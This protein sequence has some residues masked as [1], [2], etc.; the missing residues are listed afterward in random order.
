MLTSV[1][2]NRVACKGRRLHILDDLGRGISCSAGG[3]LKD[4][5]RDGCRKYGHRVERGDGGVK[6]Y[7]MNIG[8]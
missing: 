7:V 6:W 8:S 2:G 1:R 4:Y 3:A 5:G